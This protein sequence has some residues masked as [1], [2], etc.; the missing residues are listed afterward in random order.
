MS[1]F[2]LLPAVLLAACGLALIGFIS[3]SIFHSLFAGGLGWLHRQKLSRKERFLTEADVLI[4]NGSYL[5]ALALL[6]EA[7]LLDHFPRTPVLIEAISHH[8]LSI[9]SR[10][11]AISER[12]SSHLPNLAVVEDLLLTRSQLLRQLHESSEA[13]R[14][15]ARRRKD[16]KEIPEWALA[17]YENKGKEALD[18]LQTNRKSLGSKLSEIFGALSSAPATQ[19]VTYH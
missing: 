5:Q 18:K 15:L 19:E 10:L 9:L 11:I 8:H 12:T 4:K 16:K 13:K 2:S 17:E 3:W 6:K 7:F 14:S 1:F